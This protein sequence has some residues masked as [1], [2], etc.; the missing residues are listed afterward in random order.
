MDFYTLLVK[1]LGL[2]VWRALLY[3][4]KI[5]APIARYLGCLVSENPFF[6]VVKALESLANINLKIQQFT[7]F[8]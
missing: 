5:F 3:V 1:L 2:Y 6:V 8:H 7:N 4:L